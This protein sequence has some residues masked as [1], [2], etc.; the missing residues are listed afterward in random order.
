MIDHHYMHPTTITPTTAALQRGVLSG[1]GVEAE[2]LATLLGCASDLVRA[3]RTTHGRDAEDG[4]PRQP[5]AVTAPTPDLSH[6]EI[7]RLMRL[8]RSP[9]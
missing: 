4:Q 3:I 5:G 2:Q 6:E 7:A 9:L 1:A 8:N